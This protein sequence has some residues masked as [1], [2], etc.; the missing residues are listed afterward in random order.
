M[1][2][3]FKN[4]HLGDSGGLESGGN[5]VVISEAATYMVHAKAQI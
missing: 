3:K 5:K 1:V 4:I 2:Y